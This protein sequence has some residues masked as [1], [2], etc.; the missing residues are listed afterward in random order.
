MSTV[1]PSTAKSLLH[2][3]L[4]ELGEDDIAQI[5]RE[6]CR[7]FLKEKGMRR[8][9]WNKSQAIQQVISL[10]ALL[11][12]RPDADDLSALARINRKPSTPLPR[13]PSQIA[14]SS[15]ME[16]SGSGDSHS[17]PPSKN[18]SPYRRRDPIP[19]PFVTCDASFQLAA[20]GKLHLL[21]E[22]RSPLS[23][24]FA[25]VPAE[26]LTIFYAGNVIVYDG[27]PLEKAQEI[28]Q[29]ASDPNTYDAQISTPVLSDRHLP[30]R[31]ASGFTG[32]V[33]PGP[34]SAAGFFYKPPEVKLQRIFRDKLEDA[35]PG[36]ASLEA[37]PEGPTNRK[38]SVKR[39]LEK[40]KDRY[41]G[42]HIGGSSSSR[43][44]MMYLSQKFSGLVENDQSSRSNFISA[45]Q[46]GPPCL[47]LS[48]HGS[49]ETK[50]LGISF[51]LNDDGAADN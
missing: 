13:T 8:P 21:P 26:Q 23:R 30:N 15:P 47:P 19:Q 36:W 39:Y 33:C 42:R 20:T 2:K 1:E 14:L 22:S 12:D 10:K 3:P 4:S 41:K 35:S 46:P 43:T 31:F 38:A 18:P 50:K 6:E 9:S 44:E 37:V 45:V 40:R 51:D 7:R 29:L 28:M 17:T 32:S 25:D 48:G 27:V 34:P 24:N 16:L 5:T 11:E 49:F